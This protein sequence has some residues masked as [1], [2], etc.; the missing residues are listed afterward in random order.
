MSKGRFHGRIW[1]KL[2]RH[3]GEWNLLEPGDRVL[4]AVSGGPDS[5]CLAHALSRLARRVEL[6]IV[7]FHHG[8]RG[9]EADLDA[10]WARKFGKSLGLPVSVRRLPVRAFA[11]RERRSLE[12][13][14]RALRYRALAREAARTGCNKVAT[15]HQLDDAA[16]TVLLNLLRGTRAAGLAGIPPRRALLEPSAAGPARPGAGVELI[17]PLLCLTRR[18]VLDYLR[19]HGL[20]HRRDRSNLS[21]KHTRNWVRRVALPL[22]ESRAPGL[23]GRL[24]RIALDLRRD[25]SR[26]GE[27]EPGSPGE[28]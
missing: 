13:A 11:R 16:E 21:L 27:R 20:R 24:A 25:G 3:C 1:A 4:A 12:D 23:R 26:P 2:L 6:R 17:R 7:H 9:R 5:V 18:E 22:L 14:G 8:L 15:G 19:Y 10:A 28:R